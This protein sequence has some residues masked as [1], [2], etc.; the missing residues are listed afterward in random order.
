MIAVEAVETE[1]PEGLDRRGKVGAVPLGT[2][3]KG[4]HVGTQ[5]QVVYEELSASI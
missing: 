5:K 1:Y 4:Y 3:L 2:K